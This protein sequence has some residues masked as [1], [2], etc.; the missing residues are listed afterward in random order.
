MRQRYDTIV[1]ENAQGK[2][3][4]Q[5]VD[6]GRVVSWAAGHSIAELSAL[7]DFVNLLVDGEYDYNDMDEIK[8]YASEAME[9]A[10]RQRE[11]SY[12]K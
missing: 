5:E 1:I 10:D 11:N 12:D 3:V 4:P 7:E 6:G 2:N 9:K 8:R